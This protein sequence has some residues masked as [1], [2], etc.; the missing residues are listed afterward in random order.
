MCT[1]CMYILAV[2]CLLHAHAVRFH[3]RDNVQLQFVWDLSNLGRNNL[4]NLPR[5]QD[6][7]AY[8]VLL[9]LQKLSQRSL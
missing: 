6:R 4:G 7:S 9:L 1:V 3:L 5:Y 8:L 2:A